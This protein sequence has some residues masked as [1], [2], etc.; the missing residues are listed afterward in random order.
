M[1]WSY[2]QE[3]NKMRMQSSLHVV[4]GICVFI[5]LETRKYKLTKIHLM[6]MELGTP[7]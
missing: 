4:A 1:N 6:M 2:Y 3:D 7:F 5:E